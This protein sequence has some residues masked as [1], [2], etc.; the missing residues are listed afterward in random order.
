M[1]NKEREITLLNA[2]PGLPNFT[3]LAKNIDV[4]IFIAL[5]ITAVYNCN[6]SLL[7]PLMKYA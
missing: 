2:T 7:I 3:F 6:L 4:G 1:A 5:P